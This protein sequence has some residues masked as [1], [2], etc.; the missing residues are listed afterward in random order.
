ME[1]RL[2]PQESETHFH[3]SLCNGYGFGGYGLEFS[4][5]QKD[6]QTA[7]K[8]LESKMKSGEFKSD[9]ICR[10]DVWMEIL[11]IGGKLKVTDIECD[12]EY[13]RTIKLKDVHERVQK[14][15][16]RHLMDAVN[17]NDDAYTADAIM[18]T[19][20]FEDIIFG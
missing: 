6:Y 20:F 9:V 5:T 11:R 3:N 10:E 1:I 12:G 16:L 8:S 13:T 19:V 18:Q 14:T 4:Y 17:E 2:T 7:K 15:P